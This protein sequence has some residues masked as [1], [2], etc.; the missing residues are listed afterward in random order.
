MMTS[1]VEGYIEDTIN[2]YRENDV[3]KVQSYQ[4]AIERYNELEKKAC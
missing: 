4:R 1:K 2:R 3:E